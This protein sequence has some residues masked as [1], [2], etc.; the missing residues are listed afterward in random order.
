[1]T[2]PT[3]VL[4]TRNPGK[5][6]ELIEL[7]AG[8][9]VDLRDLRQYPRLAPVDESGTT[10]LENARAK[11]C[12]AAQHTRLPALAD[13]SGLEVDALGGRPGVRSARYAGDHASDLGS[14][15]LLLE[16]LR[17]V[18]AAQRGAAFRCVIVVARPDGREMI[19]EGSCRGFIAVAARGEHGFGYDP[20]FIDPATGY[21]FAEM[22]DA[23]KSRLSH[24]TRACAALLSRLVPFLNE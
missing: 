6:R 3:L 23:E 24:R 13:D 10:Y 22:S 11:A 8:L 12:A 7:F 14:V 9:P 4:A 1:M 21:T 19:A 18:P 5:S 20:V 16:Q 17:D 15:E 2:R